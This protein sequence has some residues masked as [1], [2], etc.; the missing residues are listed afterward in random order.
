[1]N[2]ISYL[3]IQPMTISALLDSSL[4]SENFCYV[5]ETL[6]FI[7]VIVSLFTP[8]MVSIDRLDLVVRHN[9]RILNLPRTVLT[10][11]VFLGIALTLTLVPLFTITESGDIVHNHGCHL[12]SERVDRFVWYQLGCIGIALLLS[13]SI[14]M[15]CYIHIFLKAKRSVDSVASH[16]RVANGNGNW[17]DRGQCSSG[18]VMVIENSTAI[19]A[20]LHSCKTNDQGEHAIKNEVLD[21]CYIDY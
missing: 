13:T 1:M 18:S 8:A 14:M 7:Y 16:A 5:Q 12:W 3:V 6:T 21:N 17:T 11:L 4:L 10:Q 9:R 20:D 19:Q 15:G 2:Y